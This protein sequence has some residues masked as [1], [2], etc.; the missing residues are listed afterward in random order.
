[1]HIAPYDEPYVE[2]TDLHTA[3]PIITMA[4]LYIKW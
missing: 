2:I 3:P 4:E 1:M